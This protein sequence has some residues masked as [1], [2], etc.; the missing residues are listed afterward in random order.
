MHGIIWESRS[1]ESFESSWYDFIE[2]YTLH[3]NN[4]LNDKENQ[5]LECDAADNRDLIPC[6]SNYPIEKQFQYEYN[7]CIFRDVQAEFIKKCDCNL[8]PR[9]VKDNQYFYEV[10]C[11][12]FRFESYG[13][14]CYHVLSVLSHCR[15]EKVNSSYILSRWSKNVYC[16]HTH[17]SSYDSRRSDESMNIFRGLCVDFYNVAQ[18]FVHD[19]EESDILRSA[20]VS[21]IVALSKHQK[22]HSESIRTSEYPDGLNALQSPP[23]VVPRGHPS[24]KRLKADVDRKIKNGTKK[25]RASSK[26]PKK[27]AAVEGDK[28]LNKAT[29]RHITASK[30]PKMQDFVPIKED[31]FTDNTLSSIPEHFHHATN[32]QMDSLSSVG[33]TILLNSFQNPSI[34]AYSYRNND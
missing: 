15:V 6:V 28:H 29:E 3:D 32:M 25:R 18:D 7:N 5:E 13:I 22:K 34:H 30:H 2:E 11:N 27:V 24:F 9:I 23:H 21:A 12:C 10:R 14:L 33:F 8:S 4:W 1:R 26:H 20:F 16:K 19:K 17:I 31:Y